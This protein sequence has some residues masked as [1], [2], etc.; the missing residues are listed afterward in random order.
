VAEL[1]RRMSAAE[2]EQWLIYY[3]MVA[4]EQK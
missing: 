1:K 4:A 3:K 2:M